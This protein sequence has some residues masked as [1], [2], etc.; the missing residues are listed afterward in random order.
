MIPPIEFDTAIAKKVAILT[1]VYVGQLTFN[2][3][4]LLYV[5][6]TFYQVCINYI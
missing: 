2:N 6:V 4:C 3:L 1:V 5:E